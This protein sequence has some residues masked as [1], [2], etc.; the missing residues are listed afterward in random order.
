MMVGKGWVQAVALVMLFGS[1]VMGLLAYRT[2]TD[3]MPMPTSVVAS[4]GTTLYTRADIYKGQEVFTR[5][6]LQQYGSIVGH[7][8]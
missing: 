6:G 3:S 8:A 1:F 5:R 7:G 2:Y 4:D